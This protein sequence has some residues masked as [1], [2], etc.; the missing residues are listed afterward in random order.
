VPVECASI[1]P[2]KGLRPHNININKSFQSPLN[3]SVELGREKRK[4][5]NKEKFK[6]VT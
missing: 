2:V 3:D 6:R 4:K 5:N 1:I